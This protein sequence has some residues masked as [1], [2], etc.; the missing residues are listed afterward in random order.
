MINGTE[1]EVDI[2]D[3]FDKLSGVSSLVRGK[4]K[5]L[6]K[7]EQMLKT[8]LGRTLLGEDEEDV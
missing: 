4:H 8:P 2:M 5:D 3:M 1:I 7:Y 6:I